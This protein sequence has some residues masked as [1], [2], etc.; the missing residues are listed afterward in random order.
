MTLL[1]RPGTYRTL[2]PLGCYHQAERAFNSRIIVARR[3]CAACKFVVPRV[4]GSSPIKIA[5][6][7]KDGQL[8]RRPVASKTDTL[9]TQLLD[10]SR[11]SSQGFGTGHFNPK[12]T[13]TFKHAERASPMKVTRVCI[14]SPDG[15]VRTRYWT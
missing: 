9:R 2:Q 13:T 6:A 8:R 12:G 11:R 15:K 4:T 7:D 5:T 14:T 3:G 1:V 10:T